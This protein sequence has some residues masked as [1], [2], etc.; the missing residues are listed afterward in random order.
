M[1]TGGKKENPVGEKY[2]PDDVITHDKHMF[3]LWS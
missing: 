2:S 3:W 1:E